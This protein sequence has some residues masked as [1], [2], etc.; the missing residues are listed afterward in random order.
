MRMKGENMKITWIGH[1]C[2]AVESKDYKIV[3]DPYEDG[4]V[5]GL[6]PVRE[7]ADLVLCS[8]EHHDHNARKSVTISKESASRKNP[9]TITE[10]HTYHDECQG[11]KRGTN[12][13]HILDDGEIKLAHMGDLGCD[14][15]EEQIKVLKEI[16]VMLIPIGGFFT[17][18]AAWADK[19]AEQTKA[20][21][22]I[23]MHFRSEK[24]GFDVIGPVDSFTALRS[25]VKE[26]GSSTIV[27]PDA[28]LCGTIVLKPSNEIG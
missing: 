22:V 7:T 18:D 26:T 3:I 24:F 19:I 1:S 17:I 13:I 2:F 9:F 8:H 23:P 15:T 5:P 20:R 28:E 16:D 27:L 14:L 21:I 25:D 4:S 10:I 11:S 12:I 6:D